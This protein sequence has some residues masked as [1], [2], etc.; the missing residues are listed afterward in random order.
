MSGTARTLLGPNRG[1]PPLTA[2]ST[3][4]A[5][6][7]NQVQMLHAFVPY[8]EGG[9]VAN[10]SSDPWA[11]MVLRI[12]GGE[13][14]TDITPTAADLKTALGGARICPFRYDVRDNIAD[15]ESLLNG[16]H[17]ASGISREGPIFAVDVTS[18]TGY[19]GA[20]TANSNNTNFRRTLHGK[21]IHNTW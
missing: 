11:Q 6:P 15:H 12:A 9:G 10:A 2:A 4:T 17:S 19:K 7:N 1:L 5:A 3:A 20:P 14:L 16:E 18:L 8:E 13:V 21:R